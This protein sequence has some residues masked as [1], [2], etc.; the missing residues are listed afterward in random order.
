[1]NKSY[2]TTKGAKQECRDVLCEIA[3]V[4]IETKYPTIFTLPGEK[5][6]CIRT[7][8]KHFKRPNI[9]AIERER[10]ICQKIQQKGIFCQNLSIIEYAKTTNTLS[11]HFDIAFFD[12]YSHLSEEVLRDIKA[13][14]KNK[15]IVH[16]NK[17]IILGLTLSKSVRKGIPY[18]EKMTRSR[19]FKGRL[20][21]AIPRN[22]KMTCKN[23][24]IDI[25][26]YAKE[27]SVLHYYE[28]KAKEKEDEKGSA[29]MYFAVLRIV[30]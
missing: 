10:A 16:K 12:Y 5:A 30:M 21:S 14:L 7:F 27:V 9:V 2:E 18:F 29:P 24:K 22:L 19:I 11:N 28:Y 3:K 23:V 8:K 13:F 15:N 1:M 17:P 4:N 20:K 6:Y 25:S 26:Y